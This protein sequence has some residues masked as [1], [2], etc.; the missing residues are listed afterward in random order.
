ME[1]HP[2]HAP[3]FITG[4]VF[5]SLGVLFLLDGLRGFDLQL[6]WVWPFLLIGLGLAGLATGRSRDDERRA[7]GRGASG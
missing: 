5:V 4:S 7:P 2:F 6:R 1:R 3:A